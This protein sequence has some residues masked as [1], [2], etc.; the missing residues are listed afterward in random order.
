MIRHVVVLVVGIAVGAGGAYLV[1]LAPN[2]A[3]DAP[4]AAVPATLAPQQIACEAELTQ[5]RERVSE[6]TKELEANSSREVARALPGD[7]SPVSGGPQNASMSDDKAIS[8]RLSAIEKFVPISDDQ[9]ERLQ[10]KFQEEREAKQEGRDSEAETLESILGEEAA[11]TYR[12]QVKAAYDRAQ[13]VELDK[14]TAWLSRELSLSKEQ[15]QSMRNIFADVEAQLDAEFG[16][17]NQ[18]VALS[19]QERVTRMIAENRKRVTLRSDALK[20]VL[21]PDQ[22]RAYAEHEAQSPNAD[23]EIFHE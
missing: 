3:Q 13:N 10:K 21:G 11:T 4:L 5:Q 14:E 9:R 8:W 23:M 2:P 22:Y 16:D 15:E 20:K 19:P 1:M 7:A 6:L 12:Q 17:V 18:G